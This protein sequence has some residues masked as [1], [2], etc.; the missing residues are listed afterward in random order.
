MFII[1]HDT[2]H[3]NPLKWIANWVKENIFINP[4]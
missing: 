3:V 4:T 1:S 2:N